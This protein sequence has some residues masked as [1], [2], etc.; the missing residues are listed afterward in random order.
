MCNGGPVQEYLERH[1]DDP[2][3]TVL[4]AGY[5]AHGTV[6]QRLTH[7]GRLS[8]EQRQ[9]LDVPLVDGAEMRMMD[10]QAAIEILTGYSAH[11]DQEGLLAWLFYKMP[12]QPTETS[13]GK[14]RIFITHGEASPRRQ[15]E[16]AILE[17]AKKLGL[18]P[19]V[20]LPDSRLWFDLDE[21]RWVV[22]EMSREDQLCARIAKLERMVERVSSG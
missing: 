16:T 21:D 18:E 5:C 9:R 8:R 20:E 11:A 12:G 2:R 15:L 14:K 4:L 22:E 1:L 13:A 7:L 6:G 19:K 17:R 3:A 10:V